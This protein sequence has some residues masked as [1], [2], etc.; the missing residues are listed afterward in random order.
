MK[1][2]QK[3]GRLLSQNEQRSIRGKGDDVPACLSRPSHYTSC[4]C[5]GA[6]PDGWCTSFGSAGGNCY[7][8]SDSAPACYQLSA[9]CNS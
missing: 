5:I 8:L 2:V 1:K 4:P 9:G 6:D 7:C 3:M